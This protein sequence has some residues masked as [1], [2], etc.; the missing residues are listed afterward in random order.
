MATVIPLGREAVIY[1]GTA[2]GAAANLIGNARDVTLTMDGATADG[3]SRGSGGW[4]D[5]R[6]VRKDV[7]ISF[8][9]TNETTGTYSAVWGAL[10]TAFLADTPLAFHCKHATGQTGLLG[11]FLIT[12][13]ERGEPLGDIQS[14]NVELKLTL[15]YRAP[16]WA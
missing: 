16:S 7:S 6:L 8:S 4:T 10:N 11:D 12:K 2:D 5:T 13:F 3:T 1:Y 15:V 9:I 14:W